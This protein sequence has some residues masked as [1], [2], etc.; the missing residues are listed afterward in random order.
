MDIEPPSLPS[1][2]PSSA[3]LFEEPASS[4]S[5]GHA[6]AVACP[7]RAVQ[8]RRGRALSHTH[9]R[10]HAASWV[11]YKPFRRLSGS[12]SGIEPSREDAP[13]GL[14]ASG[15]DIGPGLFGK[16]FYQALREALRENDASGAVGRDGH[17]PPDPITRRA[18]AGAAIA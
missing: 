13:A 14:L 3:A 6:E 12:A 7:A 4:P 10:L 5:R 11:T 8:R 16:Q 2:P 9:G 17:P 1:L 18:V 15:T